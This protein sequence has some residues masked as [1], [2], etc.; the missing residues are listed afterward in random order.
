[1]CPSVF[2]KHFIVNL[3]ALTELRTKPIIRSIEVGCSNSVNYDRVQVLSYSKYSLFLYL[4][5][6]LNLQTPNDCT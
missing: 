3:E 5:S 6:R 1:M 2:F 4:K